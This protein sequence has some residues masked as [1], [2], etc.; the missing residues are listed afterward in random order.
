MSKDAPIGKN[1]CK[2]IEDKGPQVDNITWDEAD[3]KKKS[4]YIF[5]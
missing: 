1:T 5:H 3:N 4:T 2:E